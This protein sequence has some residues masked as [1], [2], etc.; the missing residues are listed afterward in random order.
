[1]AVCFGNI[2]PGQERRGDRAGKFILPIA[3]AVTGSC[4][5]APCA[6]TS[7]NSNRTTSD[8]QAAWT[9]SDM[10]QQKSPE[11]RAF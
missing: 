4:P 2:R 8:Q 1:M 3:R 5:L 10:E 6:M 11:D 7:Q 9:I